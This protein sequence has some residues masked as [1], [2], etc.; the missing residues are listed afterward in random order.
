MPDPY[1]DTNVILRRLLNDNPDHSPRATAFLSKVE[2]GAVRVQTSHI[3]VFETVFTLERSYRQPKSQ[4]R[5]AVLAFI[6]LPN[7]RLPRKGLFHRAFDT[8]DSANISF[9]DA[10]HAALL[11]EQGV[12]EVISFDRDF[13][14]ISGMRRIEP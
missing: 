1:L 5:E 6:D 13:D 14:R 9:A 3:V 12:T 10:Y 7:V 8:Y 11:Q 2:Q 4:I